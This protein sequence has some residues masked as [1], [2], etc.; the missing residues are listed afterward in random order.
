MAAFTTSVRSVRGLLKVFHGRVLSAPALRCCSQALS[1]VQRSQDPDV[2][3]QRLSLRVKGHD[4]TVLDSF[5]TFAS[6]AARELGL[7][8]SVST[9]Q[10]HID[11]LTLLKSVHIFKK[12]RVQYE[13]R[14]HYRCIEVSRVTGS[15]AR[16][17]LE[18]V[19]RNLPEGVAM[20]VTKTAI[21]KIPEHIE[22]PLWGEK[23]TN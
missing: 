22:R 16:V 1:E 14:T 4:Q 11:R 2:L 5:E 9:P 8:L 15:S 10:K 12:H 17:Y 6:L 21:E 13:M 20:E 19:Q 23:N 18:Y 3:Y 7:N